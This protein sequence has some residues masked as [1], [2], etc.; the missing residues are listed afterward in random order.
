[1]PLSHSLSFLYPPFL[2]RNKGFF[3]KNEERIK[4]ERERKGEKAMEEMWE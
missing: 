3:E 1:M 4:D 2:E